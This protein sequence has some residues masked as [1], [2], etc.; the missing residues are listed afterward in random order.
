MFGKVEEGGGGVV[1]ALVAGP[2]KKKNFFAASLTQTVLMSREQLRSF[3]ETA[4]ASLR[5]STEDMVQVWK[6]EKK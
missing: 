6:A 3:L 5:K 2:L 4:R 1:K